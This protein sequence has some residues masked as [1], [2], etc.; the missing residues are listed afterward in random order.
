MDIIDA[1]R[2]Q[3]RYHFDLTQRLLTLAADI[4]ATVQLPESGYGHQNLQETL[5]H[6]LRVS[7][8]CRHILLDVPFAAPQ[9]AQY[10]DLKALQVGFAAEQNAWDEY[11]AGLSVDFVGSEVVRRH[12]RTGQPQPFTVW[13]VLQHLI[14]HGMQHHSEIAQML[15]AAGRSP[16]NIDFIFY[17]A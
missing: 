13:K 7:H 5:F 4:P 17:Q 10:A 15:S 3:F 16:G 8:V 11:L 14:L 12:P 6:L 9:P 2:T 1:Y